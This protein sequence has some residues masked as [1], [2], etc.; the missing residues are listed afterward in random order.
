MDKDAEQTR[1][2]PDYYR[3]SNGKQVWDYVVEMGLDFFQGNVL[4]YMYRYKGKNGLEDLK[5]AKTYIEKMIEVVSPKSVT[6]PEPP[7]DWQHHS[8]DR[9]IRD[10][11]PQMLL[12]TV[13]NTGKPGVYESCGSLWLDRHS[14][15]MNIPYS[16]F[17]LVFLRA[18]EVATMKSKMGCDYLDAFLHQIAGDLG[19]GFQRDE[20]AGGI[21][22][23]KPNH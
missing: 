8:I 9:V 10:T 5:K 13:D 6:Q 18:N 7:E 21:D 1:L 4:K 15:Y 17:R 2:R 23:A 3:S 16:Q 20:K 22:E 19:Y 14:K 12:K 11:F